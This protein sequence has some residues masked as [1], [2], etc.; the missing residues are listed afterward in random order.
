VIEHA[1]QST[2][3]SN[4]RRKRLRLIVSIALT[5]ALLIYTTLLYQWSLLQVALVYTGE[6]VVIMLA[7][8]AKIIAAKRL[9][10]EPIVSTAQSWRLIGQKVLAIL[11]SLLMTVTLVGLLLI[12]MLG[13]LRSD[14][15]ALQT[16]LP[17]GWCLVAFLVSHVVAFI[18]QQKSGAYDVLLDDRQVLLPTYKWW[19]LL[20]VAIAVAGANVY[21]AAFVTPLGFIGLLAA[22]AIVDTTLHLIEH[23]LARSN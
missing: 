7:T 22:L 18:D 13:G 14:D 5:N 19:V 8:H 23:D 3:R 1:R 21:G 10:S 6:L 11:I 17:I 15:V 2:A 4:A 20:P 12:L 9:R 16:L